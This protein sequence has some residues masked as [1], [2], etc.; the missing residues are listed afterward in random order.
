MI[1]RQNEERERMTRRDRHSEKEKETLREER[2][3]G[4]EGRRKAMLFL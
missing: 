1:D 4:R 2:E 3:G